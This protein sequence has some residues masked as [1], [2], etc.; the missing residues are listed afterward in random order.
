MGLLTILNLATGVVSIVPG[1]VTEL[2]A[3]KNALSKSG[4]NFQS[5][6]KTLED[7]TLKTTGDDLADIAAWNAAH[8]A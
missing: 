5:E 7:D 8:P 2:I 3:I 6:I 1:L 4:A